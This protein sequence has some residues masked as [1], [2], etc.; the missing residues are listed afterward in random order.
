MPSQRTTS[1]I[2]KSTYIKDKSWDQHK[3]VCSKE[4]PNKESAFIT[5]NLQKENFNLKGYVWKGMMRSED[6]KE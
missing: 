4:T 5:C 6:L 3:N 2:N 1:S